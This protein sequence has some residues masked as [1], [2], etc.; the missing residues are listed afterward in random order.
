MNSSVLRFGIFILTGTFVTGVG[1]TV[2][3][4]YTVAEEDCYRG[5]G[6]YSYGSFMLPEAVLKSGITITYKAAVECEGI[7]QVWIGF[8]PPQPFEVRIDKEGKNARY[9]VV[10]NDNQSLSYR[11]LKPIVITMHFRI[12]DAKT[13]R[14]LDKK[15][16]RIEWEPVMGAGIYVFDTSRLV[17]AG[18]LFAIEVDVDAD[19]EFFDRYSSVAMS[20]KKVSLAKH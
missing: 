12:A 1:C 10:K 18:Q 3:E 13:G 8:S 16:K 20:L 9:E 4:R 17:Q 14:T 19:P 5:D 7:Y 15:S 11:E 2:I 6:R